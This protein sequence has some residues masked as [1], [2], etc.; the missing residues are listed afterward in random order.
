MRRENDKETKLSWILQF[1]QTD[2]NSLSQE[3]K[4]IVNIR[5]SYFY[6]SAFEWPSDAKPGIF[7][8]NEILEIQF[9]LK[10]LFTNL[11]RDRVHIELHPI[12]RMLSVSDDGHFKIFRYPWPIPH[13]NSLY[14]PVSP[15]AA[16]K[17]YVAELVIGLPKDS[18][19]KCREKECGK[20]FLHLSKKKKI[21]CSS[22]CSWKSLS[23]ERREALK[24]H[25]KQYKAY[26]KK[27]RETMRKYYEK[28][29]KSIHGPNVK[30]ETRKKKDRAKGRKEV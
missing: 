12:P 8:D 18:I 11:L 26:L 19:K 10:D 30:V 13:E 17:D 1:I 6:R 21:Y 28:K 22:Q 24:S 29:Q 25:P 27:Q 9:E 20:L 15:G 2:W 5:L 23:R 7:K 3:D 14:K 16:I 4:D